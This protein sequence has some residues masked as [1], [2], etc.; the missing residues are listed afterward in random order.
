[1]SVLVRYIAGIVLL[2]GVI[3]ATGCS[4]PSVKMGNDKY[5]LGP[6]PTNT[7]DKGYPPERTRDNK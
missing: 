2:S 7:S 6:T 5:L 3:A 4:W 1:M